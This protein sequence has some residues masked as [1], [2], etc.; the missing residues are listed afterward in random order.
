MLRYMEKAILIIPVN[1]AR[2]L[3]ISTT[4]L[5]SQNCSLETPYLSCSAMAHPNVTDSCGIE[6]FGGLVLSTRFWN[7]YTGLESQGQV[8]P[9]NTWT[10]HGLWP[11]FCNGSYTQYCDL[12]YVPPFHTGL[13]KT[14]QTLLK[15]DNTTLHRH[16]IP[17]P[18]P[19]PAPLSHPTQAPASA[20]SSRPSA[21][22]TSLRT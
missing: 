3:P 4:S 7:T 2:S 16:Q 11:D 1:C 18:A 22:S 14:N 20:L 17:Q 21:S 15:A 8:L 19:P 13:Q 12:K 5:D 10:L 9:K 6:T